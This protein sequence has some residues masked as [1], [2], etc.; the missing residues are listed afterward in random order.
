MWFGGQLQRLRIIKLFISGSHSSSFP[1][2]LRTWELFWILPLLS[3]IRSTPFPFPTSIICTNFVLFT[4]LSYCM[5]LPLWSMSWSAP[6]Y[7]PLSSSNTFKLQSILS[8]AARLICGIPKFGHIS[9]FVLDSF[10]W[11]PIQQHIQFR[12]TS[13]R[14]NCLVVMAPTYL[15]S[16]WCLLYLQGHPCILPL[17]VLCLFCACALLQPNP[18]A[19][20]MLAPWL[21]IIFH[22]F[23]ALSPRQFQWHRKTS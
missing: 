1:L 20:P 15:R 23:C 16:F 8:A 12:S 2:L 17:A 7:I 21:G 22:S 14:C 13:L 10:H 19:L 9:G 4:G 11:L 3:L 18:A 6:I 5:L